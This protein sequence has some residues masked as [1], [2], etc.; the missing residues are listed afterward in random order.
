MAMASCLILILVALV[1]YDTGK[2]ARDKVDA[3]MAADTAAY[4]QASVK[5]R[6]MNMVAF[7]NVG[8]RSVVGL[9]NLYWAMMGTYTIWWESQCSRCCC[10]IFCGCLTEC[11]NCAGNA[12][13]VALETILDWREFQ[14]LPVAPMDPNSF[15]AL[16]A[17]SPGLSGNDYADQ[18]EQLNDFQK[19]LRDMTP[20]WGWAEALIRGARNGSHLTSSFPPLDSTASTIANWIQQALSFQ[21]ISLSNATGRRDALPVQDQNDSGN[22]SLES[23]RARMEG[24]LAPNGFNISTPGS[25]LE[26][27]ANFQHHRNRS[28]SRP[29][30]ASQGPREVAG[31]GLV[32]VPVNCWAM[33][34]IGAAI[35]HPL[36]DNMA[37]F[38]YSNSMDGSAEDLMARSNIVISYIHS[39][40]N[41]TLLRQ[42]YA[43][44]SKD[45][46]T[47][48]VLLAG[49]TGSFAMSRSEI[50]FPSANRPFQLL[51]NS[52]GVWLW[53]PGWTAKLRPVAF[54]GEFQTLG[55][56]TNEMFH[57]MTGMMVTGAFLVNGVFGGFDFAAAAK[58]Y[59]YFEKATRGMDAAAL[60]GLAK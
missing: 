7:A 49:G 47:T 46:E 8:K 48:N 33:A 52:N 41:L 34:T 13:V 36:S 42:N 26:F 50:V 25:A 17:V 30:I 10:G 54:P 11:L 37:P 38:V 14:G 56:G 3:Q 60:N 24:C 19:Y 4:S 40:E 15:P 59:L 6:S 32:Q 58:D 51:P 57:D 27:V 23:V 45:Y 12:P 9:H 44:T 22:L 20:W 29:I 18:V 53:H 28:A 1:V 16:S 55:F 31:L 35:N 21:G 2:V 5:A 43:F 39:P